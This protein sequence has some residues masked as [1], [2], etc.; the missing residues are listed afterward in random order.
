VCSPD[1]RDF[2]QVHVAR[3]VSSLLFAPSLQDDPR[4]GKG[5]WSTEAPTPCSVRRCQVT[6]VAGRFPSCRYNPSEQLELVAGLTGDTL[7]LF[8][9]RA[10]LDAANATSGR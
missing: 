1:D 2:V 3:T 9:P 10:R 6:S 7:E 5:G 4:A 8:L